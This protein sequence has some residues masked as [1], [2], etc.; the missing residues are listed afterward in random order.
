MLVILSVFLLSGLC[1]SQI[2]RKSNLEILEDNVSEELEK[3]FYHPEI[4][5]SLH[6][7][8]IV[9]S[10][11]YDRQEK[12]FIEQVIRKTAQKNQLRYS[13]ALNHS[14]GSSDSIYYKFRIEILNL[15]TRYTR[16]IKDRFLGEKSVE[17]EITSDLKLHIE[18]A[19]EIPGRGML[20]TE[21]IRT[22]YKDEIMYDD[23]KNYES[24][25][26]PF[27]QSIPPDISVF[28]EV[29]FPV[30]VI[31]VSLSSVILFFTIRSK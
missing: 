1:L 7:I 31:I 10:L 21:S 4:D 28:E 26:Y 3:F 23:Y 14:Q 24:S 16:F 29:I 2:N 17:R 18:K 6:F 30:S 25:D 13:I 5:R 8:F 9:S 11:K 15:R 20:I 27:T 12:K 19:G 22:S